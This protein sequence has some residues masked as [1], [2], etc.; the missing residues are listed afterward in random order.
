VAEPFLI[1]KAFD[2]SAGALGKSTSVVLK[3]LLVLAALA[4]LVWGVYV[5]AIK[6]HTKPTPTTSTTQSGTIT[7]NYINPTADELTDIIAK[8][9]K[10][11][12]KKRWFGI[13]LFDFDLGISK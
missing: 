10:K 12:Q 1:K 13:Y 11:Q 7:N 2:L 8:Q 5:V 9:V 4:A 3:G 6:P